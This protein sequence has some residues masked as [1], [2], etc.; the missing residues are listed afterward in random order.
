MIVQG[1]S[2]VV[3]LLAMSAMA[4]GC[5]GSDSP[6]TGKHDIW[7]MGA[8]IDGASGMPLIDYQISTVW[9]PNNVKGK[10]D[11]GGRYKM[12]PMPAWNDYGVTISSSGYRAFSSYNPGIAPPAPG[13]TSLSADVYTA[14]TSQTFNFDAS[15]FPSSLTP[16][17][18]SIAVIET[19]MKPMTAAGKIRLQ[20]TS[21][22]AIQ[23]APT[24]IQGQSWTNDADLYAGAMSA[25]F[26]GGTFKAPGAMLTY[27]VTYGVTVYNVDGY[28]PSMATPVQ[29]G[30]STGATILLTPLS[31]PTLQLI[32][33]TIAMC[34]APAML[35][36]AQAAV[37][38]LTFSESVEDGTLT[39]GGGAEQ[40]DNGLSIS[41]SLFTSALAVNALS[42][43]QERGVTM[44]I[45]DNV[46]T[47]AWNAERGPGD[48]GDGRQHSQRHLFER[49]LAAGVPAARDA[50]RAAHVAGDVARQRRFLQRNHLLGAV[51]G[52]HSAG[53]R[54]L[55]VGVVAG[56]ER[57]RRQRQRLSAQLHRLVERQA[58]RVVAGDVASLDDEVH[59]QVFFA[60]GADPQLLGVVVGRGLAPGDQ[61]PRSLGVKLQRVR[62][63]VGDPHGQRQIQ[64]EGVRQYR[65]LIQC[66]LLLGQ[67]DLDALGGD[68]GIDAHEC[69]TGAS[70]QARAQNDARPSSGPLPHEFASVETTF[71]RSSG[72]ENR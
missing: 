40:L 7:F 48:Q 16:P 6:H 27:G 49:G 30:V 41:D 66:A 31:V 62:R 51:A 20:P 1:R 19:G 11:A 24:E 9:G 70:G 53:P 45:A 59:V 39:S 58:H 57:N 52:A 28:Q 56:L 29:A 54:P 60:A 68:R 23:S 65:I 43:A 63:P 37:V 33:N 61:Q 64:H 25:D 15:L 55:R 46:V 36:D 12:G 50:S 18:L 14:D 26:T 2:W 17:D 21:Q 32:A 35:T 22:P 71:A 67:R 4:L 8:V 13:S 69:L 44:T 10:V 42:T 38:T 47:I 5:G 34:R 72:R 3:S